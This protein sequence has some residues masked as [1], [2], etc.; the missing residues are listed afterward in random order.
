[1]EILNVTL[2]WQ[3]LKTKRSNRRKNSSSY[4]KAGEISAASCVH[5]ESGSSNHTRKQNKGFPKQQSSHTQR[6][7]SSNF[8]N[9]GT[10]RNN[11]GIIS[12]SPP[13]NSVGFF[14][15]STPPENHGSV[16]VTLALA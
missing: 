7:F 8:R 5:E 4:S 12:E 3:E 10:G 14:F 16:Q 15:S 1:L 11:F 6:F 9:H 13:S 2:Y